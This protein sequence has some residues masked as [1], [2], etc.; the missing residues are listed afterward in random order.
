MSTISGASI[1]ILTSAFG[2]VSFPSLSIT[3]TSYTAIRSTFSPL[4]ANSVF[5]LSTKLSISLMA[6]ALTSTIFFIAFSEPDTAI[7][8]P[9]SAV[10]ETIT[11]SSIIFSLLSV[12][13]YAFAVAQ[14]PMPTKPLEPVFPAS[15]FISFSVPLD[16]DATGSFSGASVSL[17]ISSSVSLPPLSSG[18]AVV[19][20][21]VSAASSVVSSWTA[22]VS[23]GVPFVV[24]SVVCPVSSLIT[25]SSALS[26]VSSILSTDSVSLSIAGSVS[27]SLTDSAF[28]SSGTSLSSMSP[29]TGA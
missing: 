2:C 29:T 20:S 27:G 19:S 12:V 21:V 1:E 16:G 14:F 11:L 15:F 9:S 7:T 3:V 24:S 22:G 17:V 23:S 6:S 5:S 26:A 25:G 8:A 10:V 18:T 13:I 4:P 28:G